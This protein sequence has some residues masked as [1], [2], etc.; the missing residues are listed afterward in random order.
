MKNKLTVQTISFVQINN[1]YYIIVVFIV[2]KITLIKEVNLSK[3]LWNTIS[4][5]LTVPDL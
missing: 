1:K 2:S 5:T 3:Q 4:E